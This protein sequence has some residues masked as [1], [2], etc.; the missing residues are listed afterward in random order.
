MVLPNSPA[1]EVGIQNGDQIMRIGA[2]PASV[3]TLSDLQRI[4][5]KK[6]GKKVRLVIRREGKRYKKTLK[7][8]DLI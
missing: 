6:A 8:R 3:L 5:Q 7:L 2:M 4:L 1:S